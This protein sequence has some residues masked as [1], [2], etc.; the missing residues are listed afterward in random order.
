MAKVFLS[1]GH[2]GSDPGAVNG[3]LREADVNLN[4]LLACRDVLEDHGVIV[5]C[6]RT[7]D[8]NDPVSQEVNEA[9]ASGADI[10]VSFHANAGGGDGFEVYYYSSS[11]KGLRLAQ[12]CEKYVKSDLGQNSRGCKTGDKLKFVRATNMV[13]VLVESFFVDNAKDRTIG[14]TVAEQ[15]A[16]GVAY[17]KAILEYLG[18]AYNANAGKPTTTTPSDK[19]ENNSS[20]TKNLYR[21]R[22]TWADAKSQLGAFASLDNA[23]AACTSG[24]TVYDWNGVAVYGAELEASKPATTDQLYRVRKTWADAKSQLGA[25]AILDNAKNNCPEGYSVFDSNGNVVYTYTAPVTKPVE[26]TPT[27]APEV[28]KPKVE[29][30]VSPLKGL[31]KDEFIAYIGPKAV[32]DMER[33]G[34]LASVTMAQAILES[35]WGQSGLALNANNLFGMKAKLSGNT[36]KSDWKGNC[37]SSVTKEEYKVGQITEITAEFRAYDSIDESIKDHSDYLLGA[38]NG[39]KKRY[40]GLTDCVKYRDAI[41]LIKDGGYATDS[42][43]VDKV[44]AIIEQYGLAKYD[45]AVNEEEPVTP[46][47]EVKEPEKEEIPTPVQPEPTPTPTPVEPED[48]KDDLT[49]EEIED[50][51]KKLTGFAALI[52]SIVKI[53]LKLLG[54]LKK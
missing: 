50:V 45:P 24:Y 23:K 38:M 48:T 7:T 54:G 27:P 34:V 39:S 32:A 52:N 12:L 15:R 25:Y 8:E 40:A 31:S 41:Q 35:G 14:D 26:P 17:A 9:N 49:N 16:F 30:P 2:G 19:N 37:Y 29:K 10:A 1:A 22:K 28:E 43:Y 13:A 5:I 3:S 44:C 4:A 53:I 6:S 46:E 47:P 51:E 42:K 18:I 21:V 33:S 36:W 11:S 20:A